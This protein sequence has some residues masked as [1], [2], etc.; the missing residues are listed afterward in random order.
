MDYLLILL[1]TLFCFGVWAI[2]KVASDA[3]D[4]MDEML[5]IRRVK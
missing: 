1:A 2:C 4:A 3:D 5:K